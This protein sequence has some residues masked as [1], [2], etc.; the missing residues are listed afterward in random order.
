MGQ[1]R[2]DI[3]AA[4]DCARSVC[5]ILAEALEEMDPEGHGDRGRCAHED[6]GC[7]RAEPVGTSIALRLLT[8][9]ESA[10][11]PAA[12]SWLLRSSRFQ[13]FGRRVELAE[14]LR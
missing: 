7:R 6:R 13:L 9:R 2:T 1:G 12:R 14:G 5:A 3:A 4:P 10:P 11:L 8:P